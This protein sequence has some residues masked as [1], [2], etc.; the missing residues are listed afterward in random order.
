MT[1]TNQTQDI[2]KNSRSTGFNRF[3]KRH[4]RLLIVLLLLAAAVV[5]GAY[6]FGNMRNNAAGNASLPQ[7]LT[8][9]R[10]DLRQL[11]SGT[12]T[13]RSSKTSE[14]KSGLS[15][16]VSEIYVG[17]GE[18]VSEGQL[19]ALLDTGQLEKDIADTRKNITDAKAQDALSLAQAE[20]KLNDALN[21]YGIDEERLNKEVD[22]ARSRLTSANADK[23]KAES[24]MNDKKSLLDKAL[25][26]LNKYPQAG[27]DGYD[28]DEY[29]AL[30]QAAADAKAAYEAAAAAYE[31][32]SLA[33]SQAKTAL[34]TAEQ[35]RDATLRQSGIAIENARDALNTQKLR[36]S[37]SAY[38]AQLDTQLENLEKCR[39]V[40]PAAGTV[41]SVGA[42]IGKSAGGGS[43]AGAGS[44]LFTI[45][46]MNKLEVSANIPEYDAVNIRA[47][48]SVVIISDALDGE[49]WLGSVK[50][51]STKATDA[52]S[53]FTVVVEVA[54]PVGK[55]TIGM[56]AKFNI[57]TESKN[58]V[59]AVPYDAVTTDAEG[60][61]VVYV[62][63]G[64]SGPSGAGPAP[65]GPG[66]TDYL[67]QPVAVETGMETDY[68]I[69]ISGSG[70][71][72]GLIL[73]S[74]PEGRNV[75]AASSGAMGAFPMGGG[76]F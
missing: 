8:L 7:T 41:T 49:E 20:R 35:Q 39:I 47:G 48:M 71:K 62:Y 72:E 58:D 31:T 15:Y 73:L 66:E 21:Q 24:A 42:E 27:D 2:K 33:A 14:V 56:S 30:L 34:E 65:T 60:Q 70:L 64:P 52:N 74:D 50:S 12:G 45:E 17:E 9:T 32:L 57:I 46:D 69:E 22:K 25:D 4:R 55:L 53:N 75:S 40:S 23:K 29:N 63:A 51:I 44:A 76:R 67:G 26:S 3:V 19:L 18:L 36:D 1:D 54:P 59:F 13:L 61:S 6:I 28:A 5:I 10:M 11:V 16:D 68:Y 38:K 37:A 43:P